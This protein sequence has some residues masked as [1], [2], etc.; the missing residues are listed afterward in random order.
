MSRYLEQHYH[1]AKE[2]MI[3]EDKSTSTELNLMNTKPLLAQ[4]HITLDQPIAIVTSDFHTPRAA[5][6]AKKQGYTQVYTVAAETPLATRYNS[7]LREY[8]A[9]A[10]GWFFNEY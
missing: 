4:H 5:A 9:F 8:F 7:W 1:L 2:R 10:S 6:I 3:L